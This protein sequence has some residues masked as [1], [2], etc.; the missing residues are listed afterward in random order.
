MAISMAADAKYG[1]ITMENHVIRGGLGSFVA[2]SMA[3]AGLGRRLARIG[4]KDT[5]AHGGSRSYLMRYYDLDALALITR[6]E[7]LMGERFD[8]SA[9]ELASV[10]LAATHSMAKAEA[11]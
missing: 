10:H 8:I 6:I 3:E 1:V 4:L 2:E 11:L 9:S 5:F 7:T